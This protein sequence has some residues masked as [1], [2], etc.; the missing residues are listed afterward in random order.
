MAAIYNPE[1]VRGDDYQLQLTFVR[2][3]D[4]DVPVDLDDPATSTPI[5]YTG[6]TF[7]AQVRTFPDDVAVTAFDVDESQLAVGVITVSLTDVQTALL[8]GEY[9]WD[10]KA[11]DPDD[12]IATYVRGVMTVILNVTRA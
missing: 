9:A 10:L 3:T 5:D 6:F 11:T 8:G 1:V 12:L 7:A 2:P 4:P